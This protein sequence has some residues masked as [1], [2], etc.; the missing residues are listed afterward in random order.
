MTNQDSESF[1]QMMQDQLILLESLAEIL[2]VSGEAEVVRIAVVAL[3][4]TQAGVNYLVAH[5]IVL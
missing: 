1:G 5:P 4:R 3:T 2:Q